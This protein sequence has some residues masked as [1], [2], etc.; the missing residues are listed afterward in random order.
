MQL[1]RNITPRT[2]LGEINTRVLITEI[3]AKQTNI[4]N[5]LEPDYKDQG[6][7]KT[8]SPYLYRMLEIARDEYCRTVSCQP[9]EVIGLAKSLCGYEF[10]HKVF[11]LTHSISLGGVPNVRFG[12]KGEHYWSNQLDFYQG[13]RNGLKCRGEGDPIFAI[14]R[15]ADKLNTEFTHDVMFCRRQDYYYIVRKIV[16]D[17]RAR[18]KLKKTLEVPVLAGDLLQEIQDYVTGLFERKTDYIKY[19]ISP[20][21][22][23]LFTGDPGNGKTMTVRYISD[24]CKQK[25]GANTDIVGSGTIQDYAA[26]DKLSQLLNGSDIIVFD[27]ANTDLFRR[28]G[29]AADLACSLLGAMDGVFRSNKVNV[30]IF[31]TNEA[32]DDIDAAFKRPGR[33]DRIFKFEKPSEE[34]RKMFIE[35]WHSDIVAKLDTKALAQDTKG[36]SFAE[37][38]EV[39]NSLA[40]AV[41]FNKK[42]D[43]NDII[44][45]LRD[46]YKEIK[47][48]TKKMGFGK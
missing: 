42:V 35:Q 12:F 22:G 48:G 19:G 4:S 39:R 17:R 44:Q 3:F 13:R 20:K 1:S 25:Y 41:I 5:H 31:T 9:K 7:L 2:T 16:K 10:I 11:S 45:D 6:M 18:N 37:L 40:E 36:F 29:G 46:R 28:R 27:D 33:I 38:G 21:R 26:K 14:Y 8:S 47:H 32:L 30:R 34:L 15:I 23:M 24:L 43:H